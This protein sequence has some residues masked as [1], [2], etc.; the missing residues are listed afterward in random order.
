MPNRERSTPHYALALAAAEKRAENA[1]E[2]LADVV[3]NRRWPPIVRASAL[4]AWRQFGSSQM[5]LASAEQL[6]DPDVL[7][8][9]AA[10]INI[11]SSADGEQRAKLLVPLLEDPRFAVRGI[12]ARALADLGP[13]IKRHKHREALQNAL[14]E[15]IEGMTATNDRG[16][17]Y[18]AIAELALRQ[19]D[20]SSAERAYREAIRVEPGVVGAR[21]RLA[22]LWEAMAADGLIPGTI[23][24][25]VA[26]LR[27][28]EF[29]LLKR[30]AERAP[31]I[32]PLQ[33]EYGLALEA[34]GDRVGAR[35]TF[36]R[37][38]AA[39]PD[40]KDFQAALKR[41]SSDK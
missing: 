5:Q 14:D 38:V 18:L 30:D 31:D 40:N 27:E 23:M 22:A 1:E 17:S 25:Q 19:R 11:A 7:V 33:Y 9:T 15:W 36:E 16:G 35:A 13:A 21:G 2:L 41:V 39:D 26:R 32:A 8:R 4:D 28:E 10:A 24:P 37:A 3:K 12:A 34:R 29:A 6:D 20:Y